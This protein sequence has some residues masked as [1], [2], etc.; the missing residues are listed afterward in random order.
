M[1]PCACKCAY[2]LDI[3]RCALRGTHRRTSR[4]T[5]WTL[6]ALV[7]TLIAY[8]VKS[9]LSG[10]NH[11]WEELLFPFPRS[12]GGGPKNRMTYPRSLCSARSGR[13]SRVRVLNGGNLSSVCRTGLWE[14]CEVA[15]TCPARPACSI[16]NFQER[17]KEYVGESSYG[18][19]SMVTESRQSQNAN[20]PR[21]PGRSHMAE[22]HDT[23]NEAKQTSFCISCSPAPPFEGDCHAA[24]NPMGGP[25]G[26]H[27]P[28]P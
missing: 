24:E 16:W 14:L 8:A 11:Q 12:K 10:P 2:T 28:G 3:H 1:C 20:P 26:V 27:S 22:D 23:E 6:I 4:Q 7:L 19:L 5:H 21:N 15:D 18:L 9:V 25:S 13:D 17:H